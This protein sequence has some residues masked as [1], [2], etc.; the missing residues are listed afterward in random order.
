MFI[1]IVHFEAFFCK[2][3]LISGVFIYERFH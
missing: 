2:V 3:Y 1:L